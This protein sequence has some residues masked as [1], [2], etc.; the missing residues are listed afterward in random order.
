MAFTPTREKLIPELTPEEEIVFLARA[1]WREGYNDRLAGHI[2]Y[3]LGDGTFLCNPWLITWRELRPDQIIR[4]DIEGNVLDGDWPA[5]LGIPLHLELHKARHDVNVAMHNHPLYGTVWS[6]MQE[7]PPPYDQNSIVGGGGE[8]ALVD[9]YDGGVSDGGAARKAVE[10]I[11]SSELA[12]LAGHGVLVLGSS[13]QA[14]HLRAVTLEQRCKN[15]W[16]VRAAAGKVPTPLPDW[17]IERSQQSEGTGY[18]GFWE[19]AVRQEL[20]ADP[21]LHPGG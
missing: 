20:D 7:V 21:S 13:I 14:V 5:P 17:F 19:A 10:A 6:D 9:Q 15:A 4:I 1:L 12:L 8:I 11:G 16:H 2:T 18:H 3:K